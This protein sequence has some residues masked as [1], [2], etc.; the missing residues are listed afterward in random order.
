[1]V[2]GRD[3]GQSQ[4]NRVTQALRQP[5][6]AF[7]AFV[8]LSALE[9]GLATDSTVTDAPVRVSNW[10]PDN[11]NGRYF[12]DVTLRESFARSMN[13]VAVRLPQKVGVKTVI[14]AAQ[15]LGLSSKLRPPGGL[16]RGD[17]EVTLTDP[18]GADA[19]SP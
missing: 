12:G 6:S 7:K 10:T 5:G 1:M 9:A 4:F 13:S 11:Y 14:A 2:G 8:Y 3:Y 15:R 17:P 16:A 19:P 18:P